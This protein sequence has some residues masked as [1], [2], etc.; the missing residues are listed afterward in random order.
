MD[1]AGNDARWV[2]I[3]M[4]ENIQ[5]IRTIANEYILLYWHIL[6]VAELHRILHLLVIH[7]AETRNTTNCRA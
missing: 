1:I 2:H 7:R 5:E 3:R 6:A 4:R